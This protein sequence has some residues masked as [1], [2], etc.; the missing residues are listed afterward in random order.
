MKI[1]AII[2]ARGGSKGL[3]GKNKKLLLGKPLI[4]YSI[5][6]ALKSNVSTVVVSSDDDDIIKIAQG[7]NIKAIKRP[8]HL[9]TDFTPT[10]EVVHHVL[11]SLNES[12]DAVMIL[13]PTS[14]LRR[15]EH[16]NNAILLFAADP[17]ADS[18]VSVMKVPHK[19]SLE[20]V[21]KQNEN[22]ISPVIADKMVLRR[23]D[24]TT[25][26]ARNGAAIYITRMNRIRE[27]IFGGKILALEMSKS[28]SIDI[29]DSEDWIMAESILHFKNQGY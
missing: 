23:Q 15:A 19:F 11:D 5:E 10:I 3:P 2:P 18:L 13:Q 21:M 4:V 14:P 7:F 9:A 27:Y 20:S 6:A 24:K 29:D 8:E 1:I 16:I 12:F 26:W 22:Y 28:D 17:D 25:L